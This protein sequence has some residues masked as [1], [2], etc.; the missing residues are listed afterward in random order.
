MLIYVIYRS[1]SLW[2]NNQS[3]GILDDLSKLYHWGTLKYSKTGK[4]MVDNGYISVS[5]S[6]NLLVVAHH[7]HEIGIDCEYIRPLSNVL[8]EK[9][10]LDSIHPL[11]DW[12]K[13]ESVIKL[14]D[15]KTY[16][17]KKELNDIFFEEITFNPDFCIVLSSKSKIESYEIIHLD[18]SL[19]IIEPIQ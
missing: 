9:L 14:L 4:P 8:I 5:H 12:C 13:R 15:D 3:Q 6:K 16:L 11:L 19:N 18:E 1:N 10:H 7:I 2:K 17:L